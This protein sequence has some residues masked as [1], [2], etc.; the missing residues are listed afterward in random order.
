MRVQFVLFCAVEYPYVKEVIPQVLDQFST[1]GFAR[2]FVWSIPIPVVLL[3]VFYDG[4][5]YLSL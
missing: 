3:L 5:R 1:P 2:V 4:M